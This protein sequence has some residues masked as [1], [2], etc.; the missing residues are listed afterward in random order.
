[1]V[2]TER[3]VAIVEWV[4][5]AQLATREQIQQL[6]F[7]AA[8]R[9]RC[10]LRL[11]FLTRQ[12]FLDRLPRRSLSSPD[13]YYLSRHATRG[14]RLLRSRHPELEIAPRRVSAYAVAHTLAIASCRIAILRAC[15]T[16]GF[17][18]LSWSSEAE[19]FP[20]F[21]NS[22]IRPDGFFQVER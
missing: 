17:E 3:D 1:M 5:A 14:L 20:R 6:Y 13:V 9:S 2:M 21:A 16:T 22:G 18:L 8:G 4:N 10:Q 19:L 7:T 11:T 15:Q 12:K